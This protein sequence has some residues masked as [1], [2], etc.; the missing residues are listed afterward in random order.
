VC[1]G[2]TAGWVHNRAQAAKRCAV[3]AGRATFGQHVFNPF[4]RFHRPDFHIDAD[5][6]EILF[7]D[8]QQNHVAGGIGD[9][10]RFKPAGITCIGQ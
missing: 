7:Y 3:P 1:R 5:I 4:G 6:F 10:I 2:S 9:N 8:I